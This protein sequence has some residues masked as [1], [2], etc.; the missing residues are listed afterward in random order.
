MHS[1]PILILTSL[2]YPTLIHAQP[3]HRHALFLEGGSELR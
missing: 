1:L 3:D 2:T